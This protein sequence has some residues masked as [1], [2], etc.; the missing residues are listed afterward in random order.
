MFPDFDLEG[1]SPPPE[2][3][4]P[5]ERQALMEEMLSRTVTPEE[6]GRLERLLLQRL[7]ERKPEL[8]A[9]LEEMSGHWTYEDHFYRCDHAGFMIEMAV[10]YAD[11]PEPPQP[12]PNGWAALV[13]LFD[14]R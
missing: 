11:L 2:G 4:M 12:M 9:M 14:L 7:K 1:P 6:H 10:R 5:P 8:A 3:P 13:H